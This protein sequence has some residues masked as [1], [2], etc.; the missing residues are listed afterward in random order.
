MGKKGMNESRA[1]MVQ[2]SS[3]S[4]RSHLHLLSEVVRRP[5]KLSCV[6][7]AMSDSFGESITPAHAIRNILDSYPFSVGLFR[8][9]LQNSDDAKASK[10]VS[11]HGSEGTPC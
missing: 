5:P 2:T 9:L 8:E 1:E 11:H 3:F 7:A 4:H 6:I 10:Q